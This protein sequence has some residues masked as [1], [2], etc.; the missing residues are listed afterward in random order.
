LNKPAT[1][2]VASTIHVGAIAHIPDVLRDLGA[3]PAAV[4]KAAGFD[5]SLFDDPANLITYRAGTHL[6]KVCTERTGCAHFGLLLGQK[7]GL[8]VL[9]LVGLLV[10]HSPDVGM[11]LRSLVRYTHLQI[12]GVAVTLNESGEHAMLGCK[13]YE[14]GAEATDQVADASLANIYNIIAALCGPHWKPIEVRF[15][16]RQPIELTPFQNFFQAPLRYEMDE[17]ALVFASSWLRK[18]LPPVEPELRE[19]L[20]AQMKLLEVQNGEDFPAT[21]RAVLRTALRTGHGSADQVAMLLTMHPRTLHRRLTEAGS[22]FRA[23]VD[24]CRYELARQMLEDSDSDIGQIACALGYAGANSFARA[25]R[26]WSGSSPY[27]LAGKRPTGD[28]IEQGSSGFDR[29]PTDHE[30]LPVAGSG[31]VSSNTGG[32]MGDAP[33]IVDLHGGTSGRAAGGAMLRIALISRLPAVLRDLGADPVEVCAAAGLDYALFDN[34]ANLIPFRD[35]TRLF[36][37]STEL[38]GCA[39]FGLLKGQKSGLPG[40]G[41]VGLWMRCSPDVRTALKSLL[42]SIHLHVQGAVVTFEETGNSVLLGYEIYE[43]GAEATDQV[44]DSSLA[45][46]FNVMVALCGPHWKPAE[47][48]FEH[49]RPADLTPFHRFFQAPLRY[50]MHQSAIVFAASW[51]DRPLPPVE[52]ELVQLLKDQ[53]G[54]LEA[55]Y[56][57]QLPEQVRS[58]LRTGLLVNQGGIRHVAKILSMHSRTLHRRLEAA[59][60]TFRALVD[61]CRGEIARQLLDN[62]DSDVGQIAYLLNYSDATSF[63]R[64]FRRW[65]GTTPSRWRTRKQEELSTT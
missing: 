30:N 49:R 28:A 55:R 34:P 33:A 20:Q 40:L 62:T 65:T 51:L 26:R 1:H 53:V 7:H 4:C 61:E 5:Y 39:H 37:V 47:I 36:R 48:W 3:D 24:E 25:Y 43:P 16:H 54:A 11:G 46:I 12:R 44:T 57:G 17:N 13:I 64:A 27:T 60:T 52:P 10:K 19:L 15:E 58:I 41:L 8:D 63:T 35:A 18:P 14:P 2:P 23:I 32:V 29:K 42:L 50:D 9:G 38:T 59:G 45:T 22:N 56:R 21:V 31:G 6:F